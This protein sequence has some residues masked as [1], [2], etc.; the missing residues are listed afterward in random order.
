MLGRFMSCGEEI[1]YLVV[2]GHFLV[3]LLNNLALVGIEGVILVLVAVILE[4]SMEEG[5]ES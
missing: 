2:L 3:C 5:S 1:G 4:F